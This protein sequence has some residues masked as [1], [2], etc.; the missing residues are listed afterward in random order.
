M[1]WPPYQLLLLLVLVCGSG[2]PRL[3]LP[4]VFS[5]K[6]VLCRRKVGSNIIPLLKRTTQM[7]NSRVNSV[8]G[9][10]NVIPRI[11]KNSSFLKNIR[12]RCPELTF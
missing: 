1:D 2:E 8:E 9:G 6:N 10:E 4:I 11:L 5:K 3:S 12:R 7:K